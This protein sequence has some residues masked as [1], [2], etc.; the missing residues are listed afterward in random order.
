MIDV[1]RQA[2][3]NA[4]NK[5]KTVK[6]LLEGAARELASIKESTLTEVFTEYV[7]DV[8]DMIKKNIERLP[9]TDLVMVENNII[10][11][12]KAYIANFGYDRWINEAKQFHEMKDSNYDIIYD[13]MPD[14]MTMLYRIANLTHT[15]Y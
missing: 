8:A 11:V 2:A 5:T 12:T 7:N 15:R 13:M 1:I 9:S 10:V 4:A 6:I 14:F 3:L